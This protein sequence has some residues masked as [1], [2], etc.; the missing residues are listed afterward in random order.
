MYLNF[1]IK[2]KHKYMIGGKYIV[3]FAFL[4]VC[5]NSDK[6]LKTYHQKVYFEL[7][8][9]GYVYSIHVHAL[10]RFHTP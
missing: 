4:C 1:E 8:F 3:A 10:P 9:I 7:T 2:L 6:K 5:I